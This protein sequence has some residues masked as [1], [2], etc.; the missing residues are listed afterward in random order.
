MRKPSDPEA[1]KGLFEL[2]RTFAQMAVNMGEAVWGI[3]TLSQ[4]EKALLCLMADICD[5]NVGQAFEMQIEMALANDVPLADIREGSDEQ[6]RSESGSQ[7]KQ[8]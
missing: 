6:C 1:S 8:L 3:E 2:D 4:R 7:G 5:H